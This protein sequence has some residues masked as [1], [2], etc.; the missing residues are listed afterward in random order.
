MKVKNIAPIVALAMLLSAGVASAQTTAST[1]PGVGNTG[2]G[3]DSAANM[4]LLGTSAL[5]AIGGT[6]YLARKQVKRSTR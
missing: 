6:A 3:G 1:T 5:V 2:A 4:L